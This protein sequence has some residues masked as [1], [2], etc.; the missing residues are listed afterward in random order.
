MI[1]AYTVLADCFRRHAGHALQIEILPTEF[2]DGQPRDSPHLLEDGSDIGVGKDLLVEAF[3]TART[4]LL[5]RGSDVQSKASRA[6]LMTATQVISLL[7]PEHLTAANFRKRQLVAL[8]AGMCEDENEELEVDEEFSQAAREDKEFGQLVRKDKRFSQ[9]IRVEMAF[10]DTLL[11]STLS[12][13][14]KSPTLWNH[15]RWLLRTFFVFFIG[16]LPGKRVSKADFVDFYLSE[17]TFVR[18]A[19]DRHPLN[20]HAWT[21]ARSL[22]K[23]FASLGLGGLFGTLRP[24]FIE[25]THAWC[26]GH[27]A[28]TSGWSFLLFLLH[29][30]GS[31][32]E[33][34]ASVQTIFDHA[35]GY[36]WEFDSY[37]SMMRT[38]LAS[39]AVLSLADRQRFVSEIR[40]RLEVTRRRK[41]V[42]SS[43]ASSNM[44]RC[45]DWIQRN[46]VEE[47]LTP[48]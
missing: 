29:Q 12:R 5:E 22:M 46:W 44:A 42:A 31:S 25:V 17:L 36:R 43:S 14:T 7:D 38:I 3:T 11:T 26:A 47:T 4:L 16:S 2:F 27:P 35:D 45:L 48:G 21:Y 24:Q 41:D 34:V 6:A 23:H 30:R 37:C 39:D 1:D 40:Q 19:S 8:R 10:L 15:R 32:E 18:K 13:H 20:Y 9:A 28:D 33:Q